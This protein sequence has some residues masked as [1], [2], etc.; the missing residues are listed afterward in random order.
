MTTYYKVM[1]VDDEFLIRDGLMSF[2]WNFYGFNAVIGA[3]DGEEA[4]EL[5]EN[6]PVDLV[7]T[8]ISMPIMDGLELCEKLLQK[9]PV[10]FIIL[11]GYS[12]FKYAKRAINSGVVEYLLKPVNLSELESS[13]IKVKNELDNRN[14]T[15][16]LIDNYERQLKLSLPLAIQNFFQGIVESK[17]SNLIQI[18]EEMNLL[19]ID[20]KK[21]FFSCAVFQYTSEKINFVADIKIILKNK[22]ND[23]LKTKDIGY[24]FFYSENTIVII[25]NFDSPNSQ[26]STFD[27]L[28]TNMC[29]LKSII[30]E[31]LHK[32][33]TFSTY[34]GVGNIYNNLLYIS[35]S[36]R[37]SM[38]A[39][40]LSFNATDETIYSWKEKTIYLQTE[41]YYPYDKEQILLNAVI[42]GDC[43]N[44]LRYFNLFWTDLALMLKHYEPAIFRNIVTNLLYK[45]DSRL[46]L[47]GTS[48]IEI[49]NIP[50]EFDTFISNFHNINELM[51]YLR[52][53]F[54]KSADFTSVINSNVK[55][56]CFMAVQ[57][58][59][60]YIE[61]HL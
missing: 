34:T 42:D 11:T 9:Y 56:S 26:P 54:V 3:A 15:N 17:I 2:N 14:S 49:A 32:Y 53:I 36:F 52:D 16:H 5:F 22:L 61:E 44:S 45:L 24:S 21:Q 40:Q 12:E 13:I 27:F 55:S 1:I 57:Q 19:E 6:N 43:E 8:D 58:A 20:L 51:L 10:K 60:K 4:L 47:H 38:Q 23:F 41:N 25:F 37:Q 30:K 46:S 31:S 33:G 18:E 39:L 59:V 7:I 50:H 35:T 28:K 29:I 48:L